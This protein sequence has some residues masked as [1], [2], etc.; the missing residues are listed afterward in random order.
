MLRTRLISA[1]VLIPAVV[2]L[3]WLGR[4]FFEGLIALCGG[5]MAWEW[6]RLRDRERLTP[7]GAIGIV[8]V[9]GSVGAFALAGPWAALIVLVLGA[10]AGVAAA[11]WGGE[12]LLAWIAV[13]PIYIGLPCLALLWLRGHPQ[14]GFPGIAWLLVLVWVIDSA[15][16]AAGRSIGGPRLIP[17]VSPN[18]TWAGL[19]G[20]VVAGAI[21]GLAFAIVETGG[22]V[23]LLGA[24]GAVLALIE[25]AGDLLESAIK[26][27]FQVKDSGSLIPGHGG[28]LDRVDGLMLVAVAVAMLV[29]VA[30]YRPTAP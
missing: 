6:A 11:S 26:R 4:P 15:A 28:L 3:A 14:A 24:V 8:A 29:A 23:P 9:V 30:G 17:S 13:G 10:A 12:R 21:V 7:S 18:K 2:L 27:R 20:G 1:L 5:I 25:Q 19:A 16:Y 22:L